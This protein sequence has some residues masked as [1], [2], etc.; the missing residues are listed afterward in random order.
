[1]S[2]HT[3]YRPFSPHTS[4]VMLSVVTPEYFKVNRSTNRKRTYSQ[5]FFIV[6][7]FREAQSLL[8]SVRP[9]PRRTVWYVWEP[10]VC[11]DEVLRSKF[12]T[13]PPLLPQRRTSTVSSDSVRRKRTTPLPLF[14]PEVYYTVYRDRYQ[15]PLVLHFLISYPL[16]PVVGGLVSLEAPTPTTTSLR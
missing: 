16:V 10:R 6:R 9:L 12:S 14:L 13:Y 8:H 15:S 2:D 3:G 1:M 4:T 11:R 7:V 5:V